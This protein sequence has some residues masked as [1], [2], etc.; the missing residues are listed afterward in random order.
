METPDLDWHHSSCGCCWCKASRKA[1]QGSVSEPAAVDFESNDIIA[2][3]LA[4]SA[5]I[6]PAVPVVTGRKPSGAHL[7]LPG[8]GPFL[9]GDFVIEFDDRSGDALGIVYAEDIDAEVYDAGRPVTRKYTEY[10]RPSKRRK[11]PLIICV[12]AVAFMFLLAYFLPV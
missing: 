3:D 11:D 4:L 5:A 2:L 9:P 8:A 7:P 1:K 12:F 10:K 6:S